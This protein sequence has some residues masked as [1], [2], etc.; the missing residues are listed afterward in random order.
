MQWFAATISCAPQYDFR[1]GGIFDVV[2]VLSLNGASEQKQCTRT[3][4]PEI[5][6][7]RLKAGCDGV[8][9]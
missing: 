7:R 4:G 9:T 2:Q 5:L 6:V 8:W 3:F 1:F